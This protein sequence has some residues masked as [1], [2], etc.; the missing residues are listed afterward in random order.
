MTLSRNLTIAAGAGIA[1][2]CLGLIVGDRPIMTMPNA[3]VDEGA[4]MRAN[5][6]VFAKS[7][8]A[9]DLV[10]TLVAH[11][12]TYGAMEVKVVDASTPSRI[13]MS[14]VWPSEAAA[15]AAIESPEFQALSATGAVSQDFLQVAIIPIGSAGGAP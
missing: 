8:H 14:S 6:V 3:S 12:S 1:G 4:D 2:L 9:S 5:L 10:N 7:D 15:Q 13:V 11:F